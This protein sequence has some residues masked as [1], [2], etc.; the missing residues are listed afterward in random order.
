MNQLENKYNGWL[1]VDKE[2]G[3]TSR[4]VVNVICKTLKQKKVGH[5]GT[6]DPFATG[7][8][9]IA[10]GKA[11]KTISHIM[12]GLKK[13]EFVIKWGKSTDSH[14]LD[15]KITS[16]SKK[17]PNLQEI[18][19]ILESFKGEIMQ[20]PP[21]FSAIKVNGKRAYNL[22]REGKEFEIKPRKVYLKSI[23]LLNDKKNIK[24]CN[25]FEIVCGKGFYVRSLVRDICSKL[26]VDGHTI[27]LKRLESL[28]FTLDNAI[29]L[30]KFL[31]LYKKNDWK[32][33]FLPIYSVLNK[34]K[35]VG[36][37]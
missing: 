11:T 18:R 26:S 35:Y 25:K 32:K 33:L 2:I 28:P 27:S 5:A 24:T 3:M 34:I 6:L 37:E 21:K 13:Y 17:K 23:K 16:I 7:V 12:P 14:D 31:Q 15:G 36:K 10:V 19:D 29:T 9:A 22:A 1:V 30:D 20:I 4:Y 8:L